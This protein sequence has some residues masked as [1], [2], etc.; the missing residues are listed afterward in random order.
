MEIDH[1]TRLQRYKYAVQLHEQYERDDKART[2]NKLEKLCGK[3]NTAKV[4]GYE[5]KKRT[6][7]P[8]KYY[9]PTTANQRETAA[10]APTAPIQFYL[11]LYHKACLDTEQSPGSACPTTSSHS[12]KNSTFVYRVLLILQ[13]YKC[14]IGLLLYQEGVI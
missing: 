8:T 14:N 1:I 13:W 2:Y 4:K 11:P 7:E 5:K 10:S 3:C 12:H 6:R 9:G